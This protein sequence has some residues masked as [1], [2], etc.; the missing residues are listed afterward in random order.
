VLGG[1]KHCHSSSASQ[2][3][4]AVLAT[5]CLEMQQQS[6]NLPPAACH[7]PKQAQTS[8]AGVHQGCTHLAPLP[9]SLAAACPRKGQ[10]RR[11][12]GLHHLVLQEHAAGAVPAAA[13]AAAAAPRAAAAR[14]AA[15]A[16]AAAA[17]S[18]TRH[19]LGAACLLRPLL[20]RAHVLAGPPPERLTL[21]LRLAG[22]QLEGQLLL[23]GAQVRPAS[24]RCCLM[25]SARVCLYDAWCIGTRSQ[26][27]SLGPIRSSMWQ[28]RRSP[29]TAACQRAMCHSPHAP[30]SH[31][32]LPAPTRS[33]P[34][35]HPPTQLQPPC[36]TPRAPHLLARSHA[37]CRLLAQDPSP[38]VSATPSAKAVPSSASSEMCTW[39]G[40]GGSI[41]T[42]ARARRPSSPTAKFRPR[43]L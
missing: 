21:P 24:R 11:A 7:Q 18:A 22:G 6:T 19:A 39:R 10:H 17:A 15:A 16:A 9:A 42:L 36:L 43:P 35:K 8:P 34:H 20:H 32:L 25:M 30:P 33:R 2:A 3:S 27:M 26:G 41:V 4:T 40:Q 23:T 29:T 14:A 5:C 1:G 13:A 38:G 12:Q 31:T 37:Y 28:L